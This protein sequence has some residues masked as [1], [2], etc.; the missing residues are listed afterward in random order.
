VIELGDG[1]LIELLAPDRDAA[2]DSNG[3]RP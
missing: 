2:P 3:A 1:N